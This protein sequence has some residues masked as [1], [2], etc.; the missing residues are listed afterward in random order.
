[1]MGFVNLKTKRARERER[2]IFFLWRGRR[3]VWVGGGWVVGG[4][5][6]MFMLK[7]CFPVQKVV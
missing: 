6:I 3:R 1:M 5:F 4:M 2:E 7:S